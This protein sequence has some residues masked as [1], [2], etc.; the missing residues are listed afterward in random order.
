MPWSNQQPLTM[1]AYKPLI[2]LAYKDRELNR[3]INYQR[4][5]LDLG[6]KEGEERVL[7][8]MKVK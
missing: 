4:E 1:L 5:D 6:L 7:S 8:T 3:K 2:A